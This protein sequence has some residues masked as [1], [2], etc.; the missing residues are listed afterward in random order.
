MSNNRQGFTR[1][2]ITVLKFAFVL[3]VYVVAFYRGYDKG[4]LH[5]GQTLSC[6]GDSVP[7]KVHPVRW[8][9]GPVK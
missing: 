2:E 5:A 4:E 6:E 7:V 1:A 3:V 9:T 8:P